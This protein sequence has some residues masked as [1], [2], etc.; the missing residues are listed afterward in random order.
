MRKISTILIAGALMTWFSS[1]DKNEAVPSAGQPF[2]CIIAEQPEPI[3][4][5]LRTTLSESAGGYDI[6]WVNN[7]LITIN[8][9]KYKAAGSSGTTA[10]FNPNTVGVEAEPNDSSPIYEAIYPNTIWEQ[11][12]NGTLYFSSG[13]TYVANNVSKLPMRAVSDD[14]DLYFKCL[15]G[16]LRINLATTSGSLTLTKIR[17]QANVPMSDTFILDGDAA[18]CNSGKQGAVTMS[19]NVEL[20][21]TP[22]CF[23]FAI[24]ANSYTSFDIQLTDGSDEIKY[25][26]LKSGS[27]IKVERAK[28]STL[29]L[30]V[31]PV[32]FGEAKKI[33]Y[34][35]SDG[36]TITPTGLS[37][38][39]NTY[40]DGL[41]IMVF[42]DNVTN[43]PA[44]AFADKA[45]LT[46][47]SLPP[48]VTSIGANAFQ[49]C[50][51][52]T[53]ITIPNSVTTISSRAFEG[54]SNLVS[55]ELSDRVTGIGSY[56]FQ[57][58]TSLASIHLPVNASFT[59]ITAN[60][61]YG[62]TALTSVVIPDNVTTLQ[63]NCFQNCSSLAS[64]TLSNTITA[65]VQNS[66]DGCAFASIVIPSSV[67]TLGMKAFAHN[68][69]LTSISLPASVASIG[70]QAFMYDTALASITVNR[71]A[72]EGIASLSAA[73]NTS[74]SA[75]QGCTGLTD[76]YVP[77]SAVTAYQDD[78][79]WGAKPAIKSAIKAIP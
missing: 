79:Y 77:A 68:T 78:A 69:N 76:I 12:H 57:N 74:N 13:Q 7:D 39:S 29:T 9:V 10:T 53:G 20:T 6:H 75:F 28:I 43:I 15:T 65:I 64:V 70:N 35:T 49:N 59:T 34:T 72:S 66:F 2:T 11:Y 14:T 46:S 21:T 27:T 63:N 36:N 47:I 23:H 52:I 58:C 8:G 4:P 40:A 38:T 24:P 55:A 50:T 60:A 26:S 25:Y 16:V 67:S 48:T 45:T 22:T 71:D 51:G 61:F 73:T 31:D 33:F 41:G 19:P 32:K 42:S 44:N 17:L 1:C 54:C 18:V 3:E 37:P 5:G 62:C 30:P 56:A